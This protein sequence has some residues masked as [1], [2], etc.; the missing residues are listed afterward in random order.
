MRSS[1]Q[2]LVLPMVRKRIGLA[3]VEDS[4][5]PGWGFGG[6]IGSG[7]ITPEFINGQIFYARGFH[8]ILIRSQYFATSYWFSAPHERVPRWRPSGL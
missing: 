2:F 5:P 8:K 6:V 3:A 4:F 1:E 7:T